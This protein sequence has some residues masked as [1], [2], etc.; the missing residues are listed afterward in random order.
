MVYFRVGQRPT[1]TAS[2]DRES[3]QLQII[4]QPISSDAFTIMLSGDSA[5]PSGWSWTIADV[6]GRVLLHGNAVTPSVTLAAESLAPGFYVCTVTAGDKRQS[7]AF[8]VIR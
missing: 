8:P 2:D 6:L 3:L 4:P 7:I 5:P 1:S